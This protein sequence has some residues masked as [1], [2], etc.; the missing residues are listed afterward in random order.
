MPDATNPDPRGQVASGINYVPGGAPPNQPPPVRPSLRGPAGPP[1]FQAQYLVPPNQGQ[2]YVPSRRPSRAST[3]F[4]TIAII[5]LA[6]LLSSVATLWLFGPRPTTIRVGA[7]PTQVLPA[8]IPTDPSIRNPHSLEVTPA[9]AVGVVFVN[10][11]LGDKISTGTGLVLQADGVVATNYHVVRQT[12]NIRVRAADTG[13]TYSAEVLGYNRQEDVA[14]LKLRDASDMPTIVTGNE[15]YVGDQVASVGNA[16][17]GGVLHATGGV[18]MDKNSAV[19]IE[20]SFGKFGTDQLQ[21]LYGLSTAAVPGYSGG[22]TFNA[23]TQVIG[24]TTAGT[25]DNQDAADRR[26]FAVPIERVQQ[27]AAEVLAGNET[28]KLRVG[29]PA[30]LGI[31]L[32]PENQPVIAQVIPGTPAADAGLQ[33]G[34][35]IVEMNGESAASAKDLLMIMNKANPGDQANLTIERADKKFEISVRLAESP[36]N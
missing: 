35:K 32:S 21:G 4:R 34:D 14:I 17:G 5:G 10:G 7:A 6:V 16:R 26:S 19:N 18:L 22:P 12:T 24:M 30:Y 27:I 2:I 29:R 9:M 13:A 20:S 3:F 28:D 15:P 33:I 31:T 36:T 1:H 8:E 23:N 25:E 11:N